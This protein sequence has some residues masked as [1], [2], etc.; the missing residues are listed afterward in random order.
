MNGQEDSAIVRPG[1]LRGAFPGYFR[2]SSNQ[3]ADFMTRGMIAFDTNALFDAY[4]LNGD[5]RQEFLSALQLLGT[6]LWI[7]H[8]VGLEFMRGRL[9]VIHECVEQANRSIWSM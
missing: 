9:G 8:R 4:R 3:L 1:S 7:P 6:R 5:A 2:P